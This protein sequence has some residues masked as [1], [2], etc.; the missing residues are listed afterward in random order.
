M[1][2][3]HTEKFEKHK[4]S[5][6]GEI[7]NHKCD[8]CGG[9][10]KNSTG[11]RLHKRKHI[12]DR[13]FKCPE[14]GCKFAGKT[15]ALLKGHEVVHKEKSKACKFCKFATGSLVAL[16][17]HMERRHNCEEMFE[18]DLCEMGF[19]RHVDFSDHQKSMHPEYLDSKKIKCEDCDYLALNAHLMNVHR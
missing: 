15:A 12:T 14:P 16:R 17:K 13:Q 18:C 1:G 3:Q 7:R 6:I 10:F 11:L 2:F 9:S 19:K 4:L 5:H 8:Q